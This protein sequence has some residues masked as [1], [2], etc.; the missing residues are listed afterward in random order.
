V[1]VVPTAQP[2]G[3]RW[4]ALRAVLLL[5][6]LFFLS[7]PLIKAARRRVALAVATA[8]R[9]RVLAAYRLMSDEASDLGLRRRPHET[10]WE[11]RTRLREEVVFSD[12]HIDRLTNLAARAAYSEAEL[13]AGDA[14][15]ALG[16]ARVAVRDMAKSRGTARRLAGWFRVE[17]GREE[18]E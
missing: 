12:G 8:P 16:A 13:S 9:D 18:L 7:L 5:A 14:D 17:R 4:W 3:W 1:P 2:H 11:Y 10:M 15:Q 6:V